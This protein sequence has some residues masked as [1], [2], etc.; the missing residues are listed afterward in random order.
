MEEQNLEMR[1]FNLRATRV[2]RRA[3]RRVSELIE[4]DTPAISNAVK[5]G[6]DSLQFVSPWHFDIGDNMR[7][8]MNLSVATETSEQQ[9]YRYNILSGELLVDNTPPGR[10]P[11]DYT[12]KPLFKRLLGKHTMSVIPSKLQGLKFASTQLFG[13]YEACHVY[14]AK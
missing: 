13:N 8:V 4:S 9:E 12:D 14:L 3:E 10:L 7:W 1:N 2:L 5:H 6:A 11:K